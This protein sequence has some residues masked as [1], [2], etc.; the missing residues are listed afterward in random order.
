MGF[1]PLVRETCGIAQAGT[2]LSMPKVLT[3]GVSAMKKW[4][5]AIGL[6]AA[7][8]LLVAAFGLHMKSISLVDQAD[9]KDSSFQAEMKYGLDGV[10][11]SY[12]TEDHG[13]EFRKAVQIF[14]GKFEDD[15]SLQYNFVVLSP[16]RELLY[17]LNDNFLG[18]G[19]SALSYNASGDST[20]YM[21]TTQAFQPDGTSYD[22][23]VQQ[24][25]A[26]GGQPDGNSMLGN[27]Y[28]EGQI[29]YGAAGKANV[30]SMASFGESSSFCSYFLYDDATKAYMQTTHT[31]EL[32][33]GASLLNTLALG[34]FCAF[35]LGLA[36]CVFFAIRGRKRR[37]EPVRFLAALLCLPVLAVCCFAALQFFPLPASPVDPMRA[38]AEKQDE[39]R[40]L[41]AMLD[42]EGT[43]ND[44]D[45][46]RETVSK[47]AL[48]N[49]RQNTFGSS[50][51][52]RLA[53]DGSIMGEYGNK[54]YQFPQNRAFIRWFGGNAYLVYSDAAVLAQKFKVLVYDDNHLDGGAAQQGTIGRVFKDSPASDVELSGSGEDMADL[55]RIY[56][57]PSWSGSDEY[58]VEL[59][60]YSEAASDDALVYKDSATPAARGILMDA[61][62]VLL[63]LFWL[64]LPVWVYYNARSLRIRPDGWVALT[65]ALNAIGLAIYLAM[66]GRTEKISLVQPGPSNVKADSGTVVEVHP[67][68]AAVE[69]AGNAAETESSGVCV[70]VVP[71]EGGDEVKHDEQA[72][73]GGFNFPFMG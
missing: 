32:R 27:W 62:A 55:M 50:M 70:S 71:A 64:L 18:D 12:Q 29:T 33:S 8:L 31:G 5:R 60:F 47:N 15:N 67:K 3:G 53:A 40:F 22:V 2:P 10:L 59:F 54:S 17:K 72:D 45:G 57:T 73:E 26:T 48:Q 11:A 38:L 9:L 14:T 13:E 19:A 4:P 65:L 39:I 25:A 68:T 52:L 20:V 51:L 24:A 61:M 23:Q 49:F 41:N 66:R 42:L 56:K 6:A 44:I 34:A 21:L 28:G 69:L 7:F 1:L 46:T 35:L 58:I 36:L 37:R 63:V 43:F 16:S 30:V